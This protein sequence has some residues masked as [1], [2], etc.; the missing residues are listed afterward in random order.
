MNAVTI[1]E[2]H[3][4][5]SE[6]WHSYRASRGNASELGALM[7]VSPFFP[8]TPYELWTVKTGR[9][10]V[11]VNAAMK[12]GTDLEPIARAWAEDHF[13]NVYEPQVI[14]RDRM[15]AS[16]DGLTFDGEEVL[17]LKCPARGVDSE[18]W[19]HVAA[20]D[21][22]PE[23]YW[24]QI[25][26]QLYCAEASRAQFAVYC[27]DTGKGITCTVYPDMQAHEAI[28]ARWAEFFQHLDTDTPP[29]LTERDVI[30]RR[31][32]EWRDAVSAWKEAKRTLE[33]ATAAEKEA[34]AAL[35]KLAGKQNVQG[36]GVK[37]SYYH[38]SGGTDYAKA[39]KDAGIDLSAYEKKGRW[40][41]R[42]TE[43]KED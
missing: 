37:V 7:A 2:H 32:E 39:A 17:E 8:R 14:E 19:Q 43:Q 36:C 25:Q 20:N 42:I 11:E 41:Y 34:K 31:D 1:P 3:I 29:P 4:Q 27:G 35:Q 24:W 16:L 40:Q 13:G 30:E 6:A 10:E 9:A 18:L 33:A 5:G 28:K 12:R 22:P 15:S 38:V 23:H 21:A 26:Q